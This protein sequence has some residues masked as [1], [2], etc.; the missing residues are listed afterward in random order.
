MA[1]C[2][3]APTPATLK[4]SQQ[5]D[6]DQ[7]YP[8]P[9]QF[10]QLVGALQYLTITRPDIA[11]T[12]NKLCQ[13]MHSP[14]LLHFKHLKRLLRYL[15]GTS[16]HGL[17]VSPKHLHLTAFNDSDWA[18]DNIDRKSTTGYCVFLGDVPISW[19]AKK[20]HT[21]AR[22]STEAEY[23]ALASTT[24]KVLWIRNMLKELLIPQP[25]PTIIYCDNISAI[26]LAYNPVLHAKTKHIEIDCHF[27]RNCIRDHHVKISY[28]PSKQ[29]LAD[30]LTKSLPPA[31]FQ[32]IL[33]KLMPA[34]S[35]PFEGG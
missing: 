9:T 1:D 13:S 10:R 20:Q 14:K 2:K 4:T 31:R 32:Q 6:D 3:I 30:V 25:S 34:N 22:S 17:S 29:Q 16:T 23:R 28:I 18:G 26:S 35:H 12:V 21:V 7:P 24:T 33:T 27:T 15:K 8:N 5:D 11:F 19:T